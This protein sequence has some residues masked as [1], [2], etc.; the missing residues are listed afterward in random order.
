MPDG[1]DPLPQDAIVIRFTSGEPPAPRP[2]VPVLATGTFEGVAWKF[3]GMID[4]TSAHLG[5]DLDDPR[6]ERPPPE[7]AALHRGSCAR[8]ALPFHRDDHLRLGHFGCMAGTGGRRT[9]TRQGE[10]IRGPSAW[11][12]IVSAEIH[13]VDLE[14]DD[15]R[16]LP[17]IMVESGDPRGRFFVALWEGDARLRRAAACDAAGRALETWEPPEGWPPPR[18]RTP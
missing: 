12:G 18:S 7:I 6:I 8:G 9:T 3:R 15:G 1:D 16:A 17:A 14:L 4:D 11:C 13:A 10:Q 2:E 5:V